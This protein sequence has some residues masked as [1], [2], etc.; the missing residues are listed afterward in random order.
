M[1]QRFYLRKREVTQKVWVLNERN[2]GFRPKGPDHGQPATGGFSGGG[3]EGSSIYNWIKLVDNTEYECTNCKEPCILVQE[4]DMLA[5][6]FNDVVR[7]WDAEYPENIG[8]MECDVKLVRPVA[9]I[10]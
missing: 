4:W 10:A 7:H 8:P 5:G 6:T 9:T 2:A 1:I 3:L